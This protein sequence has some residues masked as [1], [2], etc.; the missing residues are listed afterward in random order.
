MPDLPPEIQGSSAWYGPDMAR[1]TDWIETLSAVE[2][3]E[4][5]VA[6][7]RLAATDI[8]PASLRPEQFPLPTLAPRLPRIMDQVLNGRG[9]VLLRG[10]PVERWSSARRPWLFSDWDCIGETFAPK[11]PWG[12]CWAM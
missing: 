11:T 9:F 5:D 10:L 12:I 7:R 1:R 3:A 4:I 6:A 8:D 2:I